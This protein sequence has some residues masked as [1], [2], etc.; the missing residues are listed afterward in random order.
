MIQYILSSNMKTV[1]L[2]KL[3]SFLMPAE[4][5]FFFGEGID[6]DKWHNQ[7]ICSKPPC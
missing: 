2:N 3:L 7:V 1:K 4:I 6:A 5:L